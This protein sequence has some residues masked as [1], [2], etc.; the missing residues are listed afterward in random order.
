VDS[1]SG[2]TLL[3]L[4]IAISIMAMVLASLQ[5]V[6]MAVYDAFQSDQSRGAATQHA[7][8]VL[9]RISRTVNQ[10]TANE[11]FPG[12]L[13]VAESVGGF[14]Y[15]DTLVV[16]RPA[17]TPSAPDGLPRFCELVIYCPAMDTPSQF[18][19]I[20]LPSDTRTVPVPSDT[21]SWS[22]AITAIK[23]NR[24]GNITVLTG[25]LRP[26][27][28][29]GTG[30]ESS[31]GAVRF[32]VRLRPSDADWT[33]YKA[34]MSPWQQLPWVQGICGSQTGL[35]QAWVRMEIQLVG[36]GSGSGSSQQP[37][38]FFGSAAVYYEMHR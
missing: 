1:R 21:A 23:K 20:T 35:R 29:S 17:G 31:R 36:T 14:T 11:Q 18:L 30:S 38:P 9:D 27:M 16:W 10:A 22:S 37:A 3:E 8:V 19:E 7:R 32:L 12:V 33:S 34:G 15:P 6:G 28:T 24:T 25:L 26:C 2:L 5:A 13:V 4:L